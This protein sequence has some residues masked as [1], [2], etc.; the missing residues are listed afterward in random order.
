MRRFELILVFVALV[1]VLWPVVFGVRPRRGILALILVALVT[2]HLQ[3]EG[4][5]WQ[6]I[7]LYLTALGLAVGDVIFLDRDVKWTNRLARGVFGSAGVLFAAALPLMLPVPFIPPPSGGMPVGTVS[8]EIVDAERDELWGERPGGPR[9]FMAQVWYPARDTAGIPAGVWTQDWDLVAP[10]MARRL[11]LPSWFLSH[12]R[13]T[14]GHMHESAPIAAG[15]FPVVVYSHGW[16]GFRSVAMTQMEALASNG[17]IVIGID[18]AYAAVASRFPDGDV[19]RYDPAALPD[20]ASVTVAERQRASE[21]LIEVMSEDVLSVLDELDLGVEGRFANFVGAV[22]L[23]RIGVFGHSAGGGAAIRVCLLDERCDAVLGFDPW[24][25]PLPARVLGVAATRPALYMRS[26]D[27][28][29][30]QNDALLRGL[31]G[32]G[33]SVTYWLGVEGTSH[34]DFTIAPLL[35]SWGS[36]LGFTGSLPAGRL[37]PIIDNYLVGFFDVFLLGTGSASLD[38]VVF[39]SVTL[40]KIGPPS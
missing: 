35:T 16:T 19:V 11:G 7:P 6:M 13:H 37:L 23:Q 40:E 33:Q 36:R 26:D 29:G 8:L 27:W 2:V 15:T 24:V 32:R 3:A 30:T 21:T 34:N 12:T 5:R 4:P 38:S 14:Q 39:P 25:E 28:R 22:D 31:A 18:H 9:A 17:Y 10:A 1:A 20:P